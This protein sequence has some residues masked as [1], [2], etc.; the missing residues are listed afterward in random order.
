MSECGCSCICV[1]EATEIDDEGGFPVCDDCVD[2]YTTDN[3]EVVCSREQ[4]DDTCRHCDESIQWGRIETGEPGVANA[5]H[6]RCR[7][8]DWSR[9]ERGSTWQLYEGDAR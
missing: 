4:D 8:R 9:I 6:G 5:M 1:N 2:Y 3:G 7:C